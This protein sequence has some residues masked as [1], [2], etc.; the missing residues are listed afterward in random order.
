M[1]ATYTG[2]G[3]RGPASN[4]EIHRDGGRPTP[5]RV[6]RRP[7]SDVE[8][9]CDGGRPTPERVPGGPQVI[10]K[11]TPRGGATYTG[12]G[13]RGPRELGCAPGPPPPPPPPPSPLRH[14]P[15]AAAGAGEGPAPSTGR[16]RAPGPPPGPPT[17]PGPEPQFEGDSSPR[18]AR[19]AFQPR[20]S[21]RGTVSAARIDVGPARAP[22]CGGPRLASG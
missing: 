12:A 7:A 16:R 20:C 21:R 5:E 10:W 2:A 6:S 14:A 18:P 3:A 11:N 17:R 13:A 15:G 19:P 22:T 9:H 8:I 1:G 4:M